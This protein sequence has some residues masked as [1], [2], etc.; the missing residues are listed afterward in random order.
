LFITR[1]ADIAIFDFDRLEEIIERG[2]LGARAAL[3]ER[4]S[5][6]KR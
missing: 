6:P 1:V 5:L 3:L 4:S 2:R